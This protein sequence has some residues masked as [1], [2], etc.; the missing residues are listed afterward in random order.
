MKRWISALLVS[1]GILGLTNLGGAAGLIVVDEAHWPV[2]P[3]PAPPPGYIP[4]P[5]PIP[6][7]PIPPPTMPRPIPPPHRVYAFAPLELARHH[8][9]V[10]I[11]D[12]VAVTKIEQEFYNPNPRPIEGTFLLPLPRGAQI[13]KFR[14]EIDGELVEAELLPADRAREIYEDIVR[15]LKDP[16]LL[17][18]V[19]RDVFKVRIFPIEAR[20]KKRVSLSYTQVL[21]SD[22]G[23]IGYSYPLSPQKFSAK[24][25]PTVS[26]KIE[27]KT[28]LP[29]KSIYSPSHT[30]EVRRHGPHAATLGYEAADV[31]PDADFQLYFATERDEIGLHLMS[32]RPDAEDGYFLLLLSPGL[33]PRTDRVIPKDVAFVLDTSGSMA[34]PKMEQAKRALLFCVENL[35]ERDRFEIIR[36]ATDTEPLFRGLTEV[37]AESRSR[38]RGFIQDMR[39]RGGTAIDEALRNALELRPSGDR[40]FMVIFLT[41]G[42]PTIGVTNEDQIVANVK[43]ANTG[44]TR[45]FCFGIG[46]DV[47][48]HL[49]DKI[50]AE[51]HAVSEYVL[52]EEDLEVKV[53]NFFGKISD[54]VLTN[55]TLEFTG[56]VRVNRIYPARIPDL[57]S[58]QQLIVV[59]RYSGE[60]SVVAKLDGDVDGSKRSFTY[61]LDL[62]QRATDRDFIARLWATRRVGYLL[63]EI[64]L[65]GEN[66]ELRDEVTELAR[67]YAI[68]TPYTA[69]LI[70][71]DEGR[72]NVS[73]MT[74]SL[75][76]LQLDL[77]ARE[78]FGRDY[79]RS[80]TERYGL[81][82]VS[83]AR[84][85]QALQR[86]TAP[87]AA[88]TLGAQEAQRGVSSGP[89]ATSPAI[90]IP[91]GRPVPVTR[92][93]PQIELAGLSRYAGGRTFFLNENQWIDSGIQSLPDAERRRVQLGSKEYFELLGQHPEV[94]SWLALGQSVQFLLDQTVYEIH[95]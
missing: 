73:Q 36:F 15:K 11:T 24:P 41:D 52:P 91:P 88:V 10:T 4:P 9:E 58:G 49:L 8:A 84:S 81:A 85:D 25:I 44:N 65:H 55:P 89:V 35:N 13:E 67:R 22:S 29:L 50:T 66:T 26:L 69:Y 23:M 5:R 75:P 45:V 37:S 33:D 53:S 2:L 90:R 39:A 19:D 59:G 42:L 28:T 63:D 79:E 43:K 60:G 86:A 64:R 20:S 34:G 56:G 6:P 38:A 46:H 14:M 77:A 74:Q 94:R 16:A 82:S 76:Q 47:N 72:R 21:Q 32:Y 70:V 87:E 7:G 12:Q 48:T 71:E 51:T 93:Q 80:M 62:P 17:E 95:E 68:V 27:V 18:Y 83:R 92:P 61:D 78:Q 30:V 1:T 57:F 40:P 3:P 31:R 54:P